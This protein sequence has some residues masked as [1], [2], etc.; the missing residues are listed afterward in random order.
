[1]HLH[2]IVIVWLNI[3]VEIYL[4]LLVLQKKGLFGPIDRNESN[5]LQQNKKINKKL[6]V[7]C[8]DELTFNSAR[9]VSIRF[10]FVLL[11]YSCFL[12]S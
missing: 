5:F 12:L 6:G 2:T 8:R 7:V 3:V 4:V 1:M 10:G 11:Y 9:F